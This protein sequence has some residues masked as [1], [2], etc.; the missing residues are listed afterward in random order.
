MEL[1][2]DAVTQEVGTVAAAGGFDAFGEQGDELVEEL[3]G[4]VT[5]GVRAAQD[6]EEV[7]L[8]PWLRA[9][10]GDD[11]LHE[12]VDGLRRDFEQ[13]KLAGAH[14]ADEGGLLQQ[15]VAGGGEEAAFWDGSAPVAGAAHALHGDGDGAGAGDL[16]DQI[17]VADVD[18][19]FE[20]GGRDK[21]LD[22][23]LLQPLLGVE[24]QLAGERAVMGGDAVF[25]EVRGEA[26]GEGEGELFDEAAS[27]DEDQRRTVGEGV[28]C[29]AVEDL[30]PHGVGGDRA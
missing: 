20:R 13:V 21:D 6:V 23:A 24:A 16:A 8:V 22:L 30:L 15:V 25:T 27:I 9:D 2:V 12:H 28:G 4:E 26:F 18:P 5:V 17:D 11:L 7:G 3:A 29:E 19:E 14:L 10:A 1:T